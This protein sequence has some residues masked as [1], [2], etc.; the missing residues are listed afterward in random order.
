MSVVKPALSAEAL[1]YLEKQ[2]SLNLVK[3]SETQE[4]VQTS[5]ASSRLP[6]P[7][8]SSPWPLIVGGGLV[9]AIATAI[10]VQHRR[11]V[12]S[13]RVLMEPEGR[14][15]FNEAS[16]R[17]KK[18]AAYHCSNC[19]K[20][21]KKLQSTELQPYLSQPDQVAQNL[22]SVKIEGWQCCHC[23]AQRTRTG[24]HVLVYVL[25]DK[26]F[27][28]CATCKQWTVRRTIDAVLEQP[29]W[30]REGRQQV[31]QECH[32][33]SYR[34]EILEAI[35][36]L[37]LPSNAVF[38]KP[39]G[40]SRVFSWS[41]LEQPHHCADCRYPMQK[42]DSTALKSHLNQAQQVAQRIGSVTLVGWR[43]PNCNQQV[44]NEKIHICSYCWPGK[45]FEECPKCLEYTVNRKRHTLQQATRYYSGTDVIIYQ[46]QCCSY[47]RQTQETIQPLIFT[48][49][50][51]GG[52]G[53]Y[54][55]DCGGDGGDCGG[56]GGGCGGCGG[57]GG[58]G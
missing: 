22:G 12:L 31:I 18:E 23:Q 41:V 29:T 33:C 24:V 39:T 5:L 56:D 4:F 30:N 28:E 32:C 9:L 40:R 58:G 57:C 36:P 27:R 51:S 8:S 34:E 43:C 21:L 44:G 17:R 19:K 26:Q 7:E 46:C 25:D 14:S 1:A 13:K 20:R 50:N 47:S 37:T 15:V 16:R 49:S 3:S 35:P 45:I 11:R 54:D 6:V 42:L 48:S 53:N 38:I 55:G 10:Y 2:K 52:F